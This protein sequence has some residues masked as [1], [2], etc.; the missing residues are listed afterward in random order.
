[1][2]LI[3]GFAVLSAD[4][5]KLY[6]YSPSQKRLTSERWNLPECQILGD[7]IVVGTN[8]FSSNMVAGSGVGIAIREGGVIAMG[9]PLPGGLAQLRVERGIA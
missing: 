9:A 8:T 1:M 7:S 6:S 3:D 5:K 2:P 4:R